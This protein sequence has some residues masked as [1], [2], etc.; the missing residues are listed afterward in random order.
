MNSEPPPLPPK[1][2][3]TPIVLLAFLPSGAALTFAT[4]HIHKTQQMPS[5]IFGAVVSL[6]CGIAASVML[7]KRG[8]TG[9]IVFGILIGLLNLAIVAGFG[10]AALLSDINVH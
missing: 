3:L 4:T 10:C 5:F 8:T 7:F 6:I 1:R 2:S 9:T